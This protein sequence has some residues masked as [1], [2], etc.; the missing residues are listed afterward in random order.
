[1]HSVED[2]ETVFHYYQE[3][4]LVILGNEVAVNFSRYERLVRPKEQ[5][6]SQC[7]LLVSIICCDNST[8]PLRLFYTVG[9]PSLSFISRSAVVLGVWSASACSSTRPVRKH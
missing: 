2:A 7:V 5:S 1:M 9:Y 3:H 6:A 8:L 4:K